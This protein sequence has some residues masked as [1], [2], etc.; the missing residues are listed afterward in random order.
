M[1]KT[2]SLKR[3]SR[4]LLATTCLTVVAAGAAFGTTITESPEPGEF[5]HTAATSTVLSTISPLT[6]PGS[7]TV[8]GETNGS[9]LDAF[10]T[11]DLG[12]GEAGTSFSYSLSTTNT[13]SGIFEIIDDPSL[14][15]GEIGST[16]P[17][18]INTPN[19]SLTLLTSGTG[20]VPTNGD[21]VAAILQSGEG[22]SIFYTVTVTDTSPVAPEPATSTEIGLGLAGT[23]V[24]LRRRLKARKA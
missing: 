1:N 17:Y 21:I 3:L 12:V 24:A 22:G 8:N 13:A 5:G 19:S 18:G 4:H 14:G 11:F 10:F 7:N 9:S 23:A 15:G 20:T 6:I 16:T 2:A